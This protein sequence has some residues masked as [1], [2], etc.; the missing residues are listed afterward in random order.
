MVEDGEGALLGHSLPE[1]AEVRQNPPACFCRDAS[2]CWKSQSL[3]LS[4]TQ[5]HDVWVLER[6][7]GAVSRLV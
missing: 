7:S 2:S 3:R 1:G 4:G 6:L 5:Q